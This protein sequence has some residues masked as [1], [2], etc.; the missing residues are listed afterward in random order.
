[1]LHSYFKKF[2]TFFN[3]L[4]FLSFHDKKIEK[5]FQ[6]EYIKNNIKQNRIAVTIALYSYIIYY[7]VAYYATPEDFIF[8]ALFT[9]PLPILFSIAFL[10][11][12]KTNY[13]DEFLL[14]KLYIYAVVLCMPPII[15][16]PLTQHYHQIYIINFMLP[17][18]AVFVMYGAPFVI[19]LL[20]V[21]T[22]LVF[23]IIALIY[24]SLGFV[25]IIYGLFL[26]I[27]TA[28]I[29]VISGY[30]MEKNN[31]MIYL[32]KY[33]QEALNLILV[34]EQEK[35]QKNEKLLQQHSR[36]AQMGEMISMIAH[37][38]RQPLGAISSAVMSVEI[39]LKSG[40][41]NLKTISEQKRFLSFIEKKHKNINEYVQF[42]SITIDDFRNFFKPDKEKETV[43]L[44]TPV[45]KALKIVKESMSAK[46]IELLTY[47]QCD[48]EVFLYQ[49]EIIQV[50]L[51]ILKNS[52]DNFIEKKLSNN[53]TLD[54]FQP[55]IIITT[56]EQDNRL[57]ISICDNGNGIP[58]TILDNIFDPYFST[59]TEKNGTGLGLYMSKIIVE[60]HNNG[61]LT[62]YNHFKG[63]C[64]EIRL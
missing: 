32:A 58:D 29:S 59:K 3:H 53:N 34:E 10:L 64:F 5:R 41:F 55:E 7:F 21:F 16:L 51:N 13:N 23:F 11:T 47:Y 25:E 26:I 18:F 49:N 43:S 9:L 19:S 2:Y 20:S 45:E 52:E 31:R 12:T 22:V 46:G 57:I 30:L 56:K 63:V 24:S 27:I 36:L 6:K 4:F 8:N 44:T 39:K 28:M 40:H 15:N 61:E 48:K 38:W 17:L 33:D 14:F 60:E 50:I 35:R 1:M 54:N 37:Q 42:L 62:V